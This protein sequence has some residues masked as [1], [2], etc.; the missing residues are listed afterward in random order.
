MATAEMAY[1]VI[2]TLILPPWLMLLFA[3]QWTWTW[4]LVHS[5]FYP[6]LLATI[7]MGFLIWA[8]TS[9]APPDGAGF[10]TLEGLMKLFAS[11]AGVLAG[12]THYLVFDLFIGA[13]ISRDGIRRSANRL[14]VGV[15][16]IVT[17]FAGP[18]GLAIWLLARPFKGRAFA[19][20]EC[21]EQSEK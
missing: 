8:F 13:W 11:P 9:S 17:L 2:N 5:A 6:L 12:W 7:Y 21:R 3:P 10:T 4:R 1:S 15:C 20:A 19:L 16:L 14:T 18:L